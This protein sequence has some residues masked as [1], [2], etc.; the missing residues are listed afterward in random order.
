MKH[1]P[2]KQWQ[3]LELAYA[4]LKSVEMDP[5]YRVDMMV[6][7]AKNP[8]YP[9]CLVCMAGAVMARTLQV[10]IN[11]ITTPSDFA[12]GWKAALYNISNV[13]LGDPPH[14]APDVVGKFTEQHYKPYN[15]DPAAWHNYIVGL[16]QLLKELDV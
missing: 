4:D 9:E 8:W 10:P 13:A 16:I 3:L 12:S 1:P 15:A 5:T 2:D 6:F 14:F 11:T 7:H